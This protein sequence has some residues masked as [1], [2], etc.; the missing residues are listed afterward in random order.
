MTDSSMIKFC[1]TAM[2]EVIIKAKTVGP[3]KTDGAVGWELF[4]YL[5]PLCPL[6]VGG[7]MSVAKQLPY[8]PPPPT[9][10]K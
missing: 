2:P 8:T 1:N 3:L 10:K 7:N 5:F 9:P 4:I 6:D